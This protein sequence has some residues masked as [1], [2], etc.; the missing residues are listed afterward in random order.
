M[1]FNEDQLAS[2]LTT[3]DFCFSPQLIGS[4]IKDGHLRCPWKGCTCDHMTHIVD[5]IWERDPRECDRRWVRLEVR[6]EEGRGY[7]LIIRN[8]AGESYFDTVLLDGSV[9]SPFAEGMRW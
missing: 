5:V 7:L 9:V 4:L 6:C 2:K 1:P 8:H 3:S